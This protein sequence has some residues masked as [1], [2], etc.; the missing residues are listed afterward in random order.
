M[1]T[2]DRLILRPWKRADLQSLDAI[3]GDPKVMRFSDNG[4]L[5]CADQRNWLDNAISSA[6]IPGYIAIERRTDCQVIGYVSL[7]NNPKRNASHELEL[8]FRLVWA[9]WS[10][11]YATEAAMG[12]LKG[13]AVNSGQKRIIA[14][15]DPNNHTSVRVL[16]KLGMRFEKK[17]MFRGYDYP[18]HQYVLPID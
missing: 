10:Q 4:P 13:D 11:G 12:L 7:L 14:I 5:T 1:I 3:L 2:T 18:D 8:G 16:E 17:R 6:G 15:V 9:V